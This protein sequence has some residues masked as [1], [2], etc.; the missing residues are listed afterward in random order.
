M[1]TR[2][3]SGVYRVQLLSDEYPGILYAVQS[4]VVSKT[5]MKPCTWDYE[6][7]FLAAVSSYNLYNTVTFTVLYISRF[8]CTNF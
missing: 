7:I 1:R 6:V 2:L 5:V 4:D 8:P 3:G